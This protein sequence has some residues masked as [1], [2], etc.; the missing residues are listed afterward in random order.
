MKLEPGWA[1]R[2]GQLAG[3]RDRLER[4]ARAEK[5]LSDRQKLLAARQQYERDQGLKAEN[6][7][8]NRPREVPADQWL[9]DAREAGT[10]AGDAF[11]SLF[12]R[13]EQ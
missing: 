3:E 13:G 12:D 11:A 4:G 8:L 10:Q 5:L 2:A 7:G 6:D 9:K 1:E